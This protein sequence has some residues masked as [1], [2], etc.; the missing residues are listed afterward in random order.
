MTQRCFR[1]VSALTLAA[2]LAACGKEGTGAASV[3]AAIAL[4]AAPAGALSVA[5]GRVEI[6]EIWMVIRDVKLEK[7]GQ[8]EVAA[9]NGPFLLHVSG[10]GLDGGITQEFVIEAPFGT[11]DELRFIVHKLED[12]QS[13]G[14]PELDGPRA[15]MALALTVRNEDDTTD[16]VLF[17]SE[18]NDAQR[19]PGRFVIEEGQTPDNI[20]LSIDPSGWF[21]AGDGSFLDPRNGA[22]REAIEENIRTSI[23]AFEDDDRDGHDDD[24]PGHT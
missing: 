22:N 18:V 15:S 10:A 19:I 1:I 24:G 9:G 12:G 21:T 5:G 14:V 17:T 20:T 6:D 4:P 23:D 8:E 11:Y 7:N 3:S 2:T 13:I 16:Q